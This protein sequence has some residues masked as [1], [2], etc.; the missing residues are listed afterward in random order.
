MSKKIM[1]FSHMTPQEVFSKVGTHL[2]KQGRRSVGSRSGDCLYR[3]RNGMS[4]AAGVLIADN[5]YYE[6]LEH[7]GWLDILTAGMASTAH[8]QLI[9]ELQSIHD[10]THANA[11][12][13]VDGVY[14]KLSIL[15]ALH[16]L[17]ISEIASAYDEANTKGSTP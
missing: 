9:M 4:C 16:D 12:R 3:G 17:D 11:A 13:W 8:A 15:A 7:R 1:S 2:L 6:G 14:R 10:N 5:E